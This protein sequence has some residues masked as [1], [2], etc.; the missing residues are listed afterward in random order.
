MTL[1]AEIQKR[2]QSVSDLKRQ[3]EQMTA[4]AGEDKKSGIRVADALRKRKL[5]ASLK[6]VKIR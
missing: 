2:Q 4:R 5:R 3:V 6:D 1:L